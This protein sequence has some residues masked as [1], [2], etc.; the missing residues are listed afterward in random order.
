MLMLLLKS[1]KARSERRDE[2]RAQRHAFPIRVTE[3]EP[4]VNSE[5]IAT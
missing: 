3:A 4:Q 5:D 2:V 1:V